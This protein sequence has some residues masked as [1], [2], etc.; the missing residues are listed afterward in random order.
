MTSRSFSSGD[1]DVVSRLT[2]AGHTVV[3]GPVDHEVTGLAPLLADTVGWIAGTGPVSSAHLDLAPQLQVVARYGV[4]YEAVDLDAAAARGVVVTN[5][6]GANSTAVADHAIALMLAA[7]RHVPAGDRSVRQGDW[8]V[9]RGRELGSQ[10]VGIIGFGR[11]GRLVADRLFGFGSALLVDDPWAP[12]DAVAAAR[13]VRATGTDLPQRCDLVTLHRPGGGVVVH[14]GWLALARPGITLVN[15]ARADLVDEA[16]VAAALRSGAVASY[17]AD[18]L[19]GEVT[20]HLRE[21]SP[22]L[23]PDLADR[24]VVTPHVGAQTVEAIDAMGTMS[25]DDVIAVLAGLPPAHPV[26]LPQRT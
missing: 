7:L 14:E 15:T 4:G 6:P 21:R 2:G 23:A 25:A 19:A 9:R 18:T 11:I 17:G 22:L 20:G 8:T 13:A 12:D 10:T 1:V 24:V 3:R 16:A 26:A 5:T